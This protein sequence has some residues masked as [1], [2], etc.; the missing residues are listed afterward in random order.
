MLPF[1][2][3]NVTRNSLQKS[4]ITRRGTDSLQKS[5][6]ISCRIRKLLI[7]GITCCKNHSLLLYM[8]L[9]STAAF[10]TVYLCRAK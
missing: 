2:I 10:T 8:K 9:N 6:A 5:L 3:E 7:A 4:L 1:I